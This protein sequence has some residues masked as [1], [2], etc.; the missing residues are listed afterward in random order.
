MKK[1]TAIILIIALAL[2][3]TG[4]T[5]AQVRNALVDMG[6]APA[7]T[8]ASPEPEITPEPEAM[9]EPGATP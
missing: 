2:L 7:D 3:T 9:P 4:C 8:D 1:V 5:D 6:Y